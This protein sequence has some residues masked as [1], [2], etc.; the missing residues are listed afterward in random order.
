MRQTDVAP[1]LA[2]LLGVSL[3][4]AEGHALVGVLEAAAPA[5]PETDE[6]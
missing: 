4:G 6:R 1:T 2:R 5:E 3:G